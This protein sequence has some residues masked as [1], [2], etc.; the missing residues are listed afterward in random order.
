MWSGAELREIRVFLTLAAG[1]SAIC[2]DALSFAFGSMAAF[3]DAV[4]EV[5]GDGRRTPGQGSRALR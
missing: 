1:R 5:F 3:A 2:G 4:D